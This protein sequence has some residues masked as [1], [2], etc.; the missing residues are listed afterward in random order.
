M[1][2]GRHPR[3]VHPRLLVEPEPHHQSLSRERRAAARAED[4]SRHARHFTSD[5]R[6]L[7]AHALRLG[8]PAR[9]HYAALLHRHLGQGGSPHA[10]Q[11]RR[12][13][14]HQGPE[15]AANARPAERLGGE[16]GVQWRRAAR[17]GD[18]AFLRSLPERQRH[19]LGQA[20]G[21]RILR[22]WRECVPHRGHL[23]SAWREVQSLASQRE[24]ERQR[25]IA[26]RRHAHAPGCLGRREHFLCVSESGL[27]KRRG[28]LRAL[29]SAE[30]RSRAACAHLHHGAA[31]EGPRDRRSHQARPVCLLH[32]PRYR[33]RHQAIRA[34]SAIVGRP[35]ER[36]EPC[37]PGGD[38]GLA[39]RLASRARRKTQH[40]DGALPP[41]HQSRADQAERGV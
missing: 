7:L 14:A 6:R 41:A 13:P 24:Q 12:F 38:E 40:R 1:L 9:D 23:A 15:E 34:V 30:L 22:A 20:P 25:H 32:R 27:G 5:I 10:R 39:A 21:G 4:R 29:R 16:R 3:P 11:H 28:R 17:E 18:A 35:G 36:A 33:L 2:S 26:K 31:R 19:R 8:A 37:A